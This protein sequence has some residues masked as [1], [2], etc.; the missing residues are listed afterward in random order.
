LVELL[1]VPPVTTVSLPNALNPDT[2]NV[3]PVLF[4]NVAV[5]AEYVPPLTNISVN[6][7]TLKVPPV[8]FANV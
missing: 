1:G 5:P 3:P 2:L 7:D 8:L 6:A 4:V